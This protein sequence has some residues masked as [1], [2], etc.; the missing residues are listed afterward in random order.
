M[1]RRLIPNSTRQFVRKVRHGRQIRRFGFGD[2][3]DPLFARLGEWVSEGMTAIDVGAA[4]G[5]FTLTLSH[6][7]GPRGRVIAFEPMPDQFELLVC[8]AR[9]SPYPNTTCL[10]LAASDV[11]GSCSLAAPLSAGV[12]NW[13]Q[14]RIS[15]VGTPAICVTLDHIPQPEPVGFLKV[16][17]EGHDF[18]VLR[19]GEAMI[20]EYRPAI[21]IEAGGAEMSDWL[22]DLGYREPVTEQGSPNRVFLV[23]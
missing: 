9:L 10:Q 19:G 2:A 8:N 17:A 15:D 3:G 11:V 23:A 20:R 16:D 12:P 21:F 6:L 18:K 4:V 13:Y 22:R 1:I 7:V 5:T 14:S